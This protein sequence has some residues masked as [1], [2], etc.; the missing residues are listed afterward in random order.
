MPP[1]TNP[2][3]YAV[4]PRSIGIAGGGEKYVGSFLKA[5]LQPANQAMEEWPPALRD[6]A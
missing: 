1:L 5:P 2:R 4:R 3:V 6:A